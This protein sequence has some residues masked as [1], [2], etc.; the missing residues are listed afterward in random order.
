MRAPD[1]AGGQKSAVS[2]QELRKP[3]EE[4]IERL[5]TADDEC[6]IQLVT[7]S[8][9]RA[10]YTLVILFGATLHRL[11][12]LGRPPGATYVRLHMINALQIQLAYKFWLWVDSS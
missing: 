9:G 1:P 8:I 3:M 2:D 5:L 11:N 4:Y 6:R 7:V 12:I 10:S